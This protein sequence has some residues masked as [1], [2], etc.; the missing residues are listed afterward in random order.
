MNGK[1]FG[2]GRPH[3][4]TGQRLVASFHASLALVFV[5]V[6]FVDASGS[7]GFSDLARLVTVILAGM[8]LLA[9]ATVTAVARYAVSNGAV[10]I[11]LLALGPP[12]LMV[13]A[14]FAIRGV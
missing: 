4:S 1:G 6:S 3:L 12:A 8:Y 7:E 13:V 10:R 2:A 9:V 14:I 5:V 11:G